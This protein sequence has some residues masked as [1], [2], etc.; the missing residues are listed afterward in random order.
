M[1]LTRSLTLRL[2]KRQ[3]W[4]ARRAPRPPRR[5]SRPKLRPAAAW[6]AAART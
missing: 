1:H 2:L 4:S 5:R 3:E 6:S